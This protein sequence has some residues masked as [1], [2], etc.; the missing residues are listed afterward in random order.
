MAANSERSEA[1][2][3]TVHRI[4]EI[5]RV[6]GTQKAGLRRIKGEL[7]RLAERAEWFTA[8]EFPPPYGAPPENSCVYRISEDADTHAFALYIQSVNGKLDVPPH[9]HTTWAV[10][11]GIHGVE[12]N[13]FYDR[14]EDGVELTGSHRV[15]HG[16]GVTLLPDDLHSIHIN[17][18]RPV[19]NFHMYGLGLEYLE[20]R[21]MFDRKSGQW[22]DFSDDSN[23]IDARY[24]ST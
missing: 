11:V 12:L 19:I 21:K 24:V 20:N 1:V 2:R 22:R 15:E 16:T 14:T 23:I 13:R 6:D 3:T 5:G 4:R 9:D 17:D 18:Q 8:D 7:I 10:I